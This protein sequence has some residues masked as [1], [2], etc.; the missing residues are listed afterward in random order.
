M[1][2][3]GASRCG[4]SS[5]DAIDLRHLD[6]R[7]RLAPGCRHSENNTGVRISPPPPTIESMKPASSEAPATQNHSMCAIVP[8]SVGGFAVP[9]KRAKKSADL[10]RFRKHVGI[11]CADALCFLVLILARVSPRTLACDGGP[12]A[13]GATLNA[14]TSAVH[15]GLPAAL[16]APHPE[17]RSFTSAAKCNFWHG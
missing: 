12:S 17:A 15:R 6:A 11:S 8:G 4:S 13:S 9:Q 16:G 2:R 7:L 10:R 3:C 5:A 14:C 1:A